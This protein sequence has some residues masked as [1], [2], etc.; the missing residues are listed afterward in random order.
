M[1]SKHSW[2]GDSFAIGL[3]LLNF[4]HNFSA[5]MTPL[6]DVIRLRQDRVGR[7]PEYLEAVLLS[8]RRRCPFRG[9][10]EVK[11]ERCKLSKLLDASAALRNRQELMLLPQT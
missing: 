11:I 9:H 8:L 1:H 4:S 10:L 2:M 5:G 7:M 6:D 3:A